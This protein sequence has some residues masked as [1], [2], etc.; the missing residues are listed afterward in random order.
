[1]VSSHNPAFQSDI[2]HQVTATKGVA[3]AC[4]HP[5]FVCPALQVMWLP[6]AAIRRPLQGSRSNGETS[7]ARQQAAEGGLQ[8]E[9][10]CCAA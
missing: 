6:V 4:E 8:G 1:M 9:Q 5:N 10:W 7:G 3:V 2:T